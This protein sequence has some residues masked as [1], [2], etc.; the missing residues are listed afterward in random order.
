MNVAQCSANWFNFSAEHICVA[1]FAHTLKRSASAAWS[2]FESNDAS[3][4]GMRFPPADRKFPR[5]RG[6]FKK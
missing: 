5:S 2:N 6:G 3:R 1:R 4:P